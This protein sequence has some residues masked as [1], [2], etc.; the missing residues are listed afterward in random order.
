[1]CGGVAEEVVIVEGGF[2]G[3][4]SSKEKCKEEDPQGARSWVVALG[5]VHGPPMFRE[6]PSARMFGG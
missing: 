6:V 4:A 1:M 3:S 2:L 5:D